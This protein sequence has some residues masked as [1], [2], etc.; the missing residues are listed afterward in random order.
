MTADQP[1]TDQGRDGRLIRAR[2]RGA[3]LL[4]L[5]MVCTIIGRLYVL[6]VAEYDKYQTLSLGNHIRLQALPPVRGLIL[7]R[8][9]EVLARNKPVYELQV[10]PEKTENLEWVLQEVGKIVTL[11]ERELA[12]FRKRLHQRPSFEKHLLKSRLTD[13]EVARFAVNEYRYPGV[14]LDAGLQ[15]VYPAGELTG[16]A[17]GYVGR[18]N[19]REERRLDPVAYQEVSHIGKLGVEMYYE[20][21]LLGR[22]GFEQVEIDA[23]GR[24]VRTIS[25][26][27]ARPGKNLH[28][29]LDRGLQQVAWEALGSRRGAVVALQPDTGEIL[30]LVSAPT[31]DTNLFTDGIDKESYNALR[32]LAGTPLLNRAL[33]GRYA[34]G[35]TIKPVIALAALEADL[36]PRQKIYCPGWFMLSGSSRKYRCWK[37]EGHGWV[38]LHD[39]LEQSCD[40]YFYN[41]GAKLGIELMADIL[42]RFGFGRQTGVDLPDEPDGLV[43]TPAWKQRTRGRSWYP[44]EDVITAIGQ[45]YLL[46]TPLQLATAT[47][48]LANHGRSV[49]PRLLRGLEN[50]LTGE[51]EYPAGRVVQSATIKDPAVY[52]RIIDGMTAVM[53]GPRGT[54]RASGRHSA[55]QMAGKTGTAQ[56]IAIPQEQDYDE[57]GVPEHLRDHALFIAF[58][59]V[60]QP[61][62]A[63]AVIIENGG[64]GARSAAPV[65]RKILD[66]FFIQRLRRAAIGGI[67]RVFG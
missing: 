50:P 57:Q 5:L 29:T 6:Q 56:V 24:V 39:A 8:Y 20:E 4:V 2:L 61:Q 64:S 31:Y 11:S 19:E 32:S 17:L 40:T 21:E 41:T 59:P 47:A 66:Y 23:H 49:R 63:V 37:R 14:S 55:Y 33:Y 16:H 65:A 54:A 42:N 34:P 36:D 12:R 52:Q 9:G 53:H 27:A 28:L 60:E 44:G 13:Q 51:M 3:A 26:G 43:P 46:V 58:A 10:I 67:T 25:R 7:D 48:T 22:G 30:A 35:S 45:G 15:R 62:I 38:H 18:I 1:I